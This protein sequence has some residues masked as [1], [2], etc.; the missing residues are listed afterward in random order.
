TKLEH[1]TLDSI[2]SL[3][4]FLKFYQKTKKDCDKHMISYNEKLLKIKEDDEITKALKEL[5]RMNS[6]GK[7]LRASLIA[8]GY[9][10]SEKKDNKYLNLAIALEI[11][12]TAILVHDDIIDNDV[13]RRGKPTIPESYKNHYNNP[14][15]KNKEFDEKLKNL[16]NSMAICIGDLGFYLANGI[17]I[18]AYKNEECLSD[19]LSY[20]NEM[21]IKTCKG[22]MLDVILPFKEQYFKSDKNLHQKIMEIYKLKTA[23]YSVIGPFCLGLILSGADKKQINAMEE[24]LLNAGIAFQIKDD[25]LGIYGNEKLTGKPNTS[26]A[27]EFKQTILYS[28]VMK[29]EYKEELLKYYGKKHIS[30]KEAKEIIN[31]FDK[32]GAKAYSKKIMNDL[33]QTSLDALEKENINKKYKDI[34]KGFIIYLRHRSK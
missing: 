16:S 15:T 32:S 31:I 5:V 3:Y 29:T 19:L 2:N 26:D 9:K 6:G 8:L 20:Y 7:F 30:E 22:E 21:V 25:I 10:S 18:D 1:I 11:F 13:M 24:I 34:L 27:E 33:F 4:Q 12:Q 17:I 28:Y 23:W 14:L